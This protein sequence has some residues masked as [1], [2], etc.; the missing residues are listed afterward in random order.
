MRLFCFAD[1]FLVVGAEFEPVCPQER[2]L[3]RLS[4]WDA[5]C[6]I[7]V[8]GRLQFILARELVPCFGSSGTGAAWNRAEVREGGFLEVVERKREGYVFVCRSLH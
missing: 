7:V 8:Q 3:P 5:C 6:Y 2:C 1:K 4:R